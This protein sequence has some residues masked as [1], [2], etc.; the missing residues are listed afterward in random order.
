MQILTT[1]GII[2]FYSVLL[3]F[4]LSV[5]YQ[6]PSED[7]CRIFKKGYKNKTMKSLLIK[8]FYGIINCKNISLNH[9]S[10]I[11]HFFT[12]RK[13]QR[14]SDEFRRYRNVTL[15]LNGL[16]LNSFG[17]VYICKLHTECFQLCYFTGITHLICTSSTWVIE[18]IG[19]MMRFI[20]IGLN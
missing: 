11:S 5:S 15:D 10:P 7:G 16:I 14:F 8:Y 9:F 2:K 19:L 17:N 3:P 6:V 4:V 13:R 20:I 12:P 18:L 1:F